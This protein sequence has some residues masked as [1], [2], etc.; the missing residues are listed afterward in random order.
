MTGSNNCYIVSIIQALKKSSFM[1]Y[2][3]KRGYRADLIRGDPAVC[4]ILA[5]GTREGFPGIARPPFLMGKA[6]QPALPEL[7][8]TH[9][10]EVPDP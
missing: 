2:L 10:A 5:H 4:R 7:P 8:E 1:N 3:K 6:A 9:L